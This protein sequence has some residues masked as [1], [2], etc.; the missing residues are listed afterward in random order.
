MNKVIKFFGLSISLGSNLLLLYFIV[1]F[2]LTPK[3]V[4]EILEPN[5]IISGF[6]VLLLVFSVGVIYSLIWNLKK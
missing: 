4:I 6:E 3:L 2:F 5:R 1:R